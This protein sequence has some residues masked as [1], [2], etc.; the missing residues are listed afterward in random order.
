VYR[1]NFHK[2]TACEAPSTPLFLP[3]VGAAVP[4][5]EDLVGGLIAFRLEVC[6]IGAARNEFDVNKHHNLI[7]PK[8]HINFVVTFYGQ[9]ASAAFCI[10]I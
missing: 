6:L 10:Q 2:L 9:S 3:V 8:S 7:K 1:E 4:S 5:G